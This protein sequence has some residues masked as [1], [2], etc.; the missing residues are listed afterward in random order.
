VGGNSKVEM[1]RLREVFEALGYKNVRSYINSGNVLFE[2]KKASDRTIA[3]EIEQSLLTHFGFVIQVVVREGENIKN[4]NQA[5]PKAWV[6]NSDMKS[7]VLFLWEEYDSKDTLKLLKINPD[8][9]TVKYVSGALLWN[10]LRKD[11]GKSGMNKL[12]GTAVYKNS[13]ARNVNTVRKLASLLA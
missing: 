2:R 5:I 4:V 7:D 3:A 9:D 12:I 6:N 1:K 13:T 8:V 11:Y 10:V